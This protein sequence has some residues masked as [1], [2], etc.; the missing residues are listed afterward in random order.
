VL[1]KLYLMINIEEIIHSVQQYDPEVDTD[2]IR[3]AYDFAVKAHAGAKRLSGED[4]TQHELATALT[5]SKLRLDL[6][7]IIAGILHDVPEDTTATIEEIRKIFG[8][9]VASLVQGITKLGTLKYRGLERYAE[10]LRKMFMAMAEDIRVVLIKF[11][12]RIHNLQTLE[13]NRPDKRKR[14]ALESLEIYAPIANRLG[15]GEIKGQ[16]EDLAFP[17]VYPKEYAMIKKI[18]ESRLKVERKYIDKVKKTIEKS[19]IQEKID[20]VS[21]EGRIKHLYSLYKKLVRKEMNIDKIYDLIAV[22]VIVKDVA[23]CYRVLGLIHKKWTPL[24]GRIKDYIAQPKPNGYQSLHTTVFA[25][26]GKIV[27]FQIRDLAMHETAEFGV[28]THWRYKE[29]DRIKMNKE[30]TEWIQKLLDLQKEMLD[31]KKYLQEIKVDIFQ[32]HIFVFTPKGDVIDLPEGSTPI[33]FAYHIHSDVGNKCIGS[34]INEEIAPL[35]TV[36]KSGDVVEIMINK[37]RQKPNIDW[38]NIVKTH[39]AKEKIKN[40]LKEDKDKSIRNFF[41][42]N[43]PKE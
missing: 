34:L 9:E 36:L 11:A 28:A 35:D 5:L 19:L 27:E 3:E 7:T 10:N 6:P 40:S 29:S 30:K 39:L 1:G 25:E 33:D 12:D 22:R 20:F 2:L 14:I 26:S 15:M 4:Y 31:D 13:Y 24:K 17:Y 18:A 32:N 41:K 23:D 16:L 42:L 37:S 43:K 8:K 38:L 21:V